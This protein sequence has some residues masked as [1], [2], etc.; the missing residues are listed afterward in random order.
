MADSPI[1]DLLTEEH[2]GPW[3]LIAAEGAWNDSFYDLE[4]LLAQLTLYQVHTFFGSY[5][6][7][8]EKNSSV[9]TLQVRVF[10]S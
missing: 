9:Y 5:I 10:F 1:F 6:L 2:L 7:P 4:R 8:D 3:P